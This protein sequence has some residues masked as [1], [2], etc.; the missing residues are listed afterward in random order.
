MNGYLHLQNLAVEKKMKDQFEELRDRIVTSHSDLKTAKLN[1]TELLV[2]K[3]LIQ[4]MNNL[5]DTS[6][7]SSLR[8]RKSTAQDVKNL[9]VEE[10]NMR[11]QRQTQMAEIENAVR[12]YYDKLLDGLK[13]ENK[14]TLNK[15]KETYEAKKQVIQEELKNV[16]QKTQKSLQVEEKLKNTEKEHIEQQQILSN[17]KADYENIL[18]KYQ[19]KADK[20][21]SQE[22]KI[23]EL[24]EKLV[25][26]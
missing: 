18:K 23:E 7:Q 11:R 15:I 19:S 4:K 8:P 16:E 26:K 3:D 1:E 17:I 13:L 14:A 2:M 25:K 10:Q 5:K 21:K 24:Q 6:R 12:Q 22:K 9:E 20:I